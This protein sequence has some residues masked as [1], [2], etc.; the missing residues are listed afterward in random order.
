MAVYV[1][2]LR[3]VNVGGHAPLPMATLRSE[4]VRAGFEDVR[5]L[6]QSGNVVLRSSERSPAK[7]ERTLE[8]LLEDR[9]G[10]VADVLVRSAPEWTSIVQGNPYTREALDDPARLILLCLKSA[11]PS[12]ATEALRAA[13]RGPETGVVAGSHAYLVYPDGMGTSRLTTVVLERTL[14]TRGT[15][16]NWNTVRKLEGLANA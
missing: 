9:C 2:L 14:G 8:S 12:G 15:A 7:L 4:L 3:A 16:R 10:V 13:I 11:A 6:L 1:V 5:T